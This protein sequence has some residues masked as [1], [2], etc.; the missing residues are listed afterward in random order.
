MRGT[1]R[2]PA[3]ERANLEA[4]ASSCVAAESLLRCEVAEIEQAEPGEQCVPRRE[5]GNEV[6]EVLPDVR[7]RAGGRRIHDERNPSPAATSRVFDVEFEWR[8]HTC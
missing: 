8:T 3:W 6:N 4:P 2:A 5:P 7:G 1:M